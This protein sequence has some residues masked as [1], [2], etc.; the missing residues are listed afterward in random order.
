MGMSI[1]STVTSPLFSEIELRYKVALH[2]HFQWSTSPLTYRTLVISKHL[3]VYPIKRNNEEL[4]IGHCF[5]FA[6]V[7]AESKINYMQ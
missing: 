6:L 7:E 5:T 4:Y 1:C 3:F 2:L